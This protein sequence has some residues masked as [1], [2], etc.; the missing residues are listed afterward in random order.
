[1]TRVN[2][3]ILQT[4]RRRKGWSQDRLSEM[5]GV[6]KQTISRIER[7]KQDS[8]QENTIKLLARALG[9]EPAEL[10]REALAPET[11]RESEPV[12]NKSPFGLS[13]AADNALYLV[14]E[15]YWVKHWQIMELAPL[16]FCWAA[17][18]SLRERRKR[19]EKLKE[20][21][22]TA[23][24]LEQEMPHLPDPNFSYSEEKIKKETESIESH[25]LFATTMDTEDFIDGPFY[26]TDRNENPFSNFLEKQIGAL[27]TVATFEEFPAFDWPVY[28]VCPDEA[29]R[30]VD[31]DEELAEAV[32]DGR[33]ALREMPKKLQDSSIL[34]SAERA[35]WAREQLEE[36]HKRIMAQIE[37][38]T[39]KPKAVP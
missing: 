23:R 20:A 35:A 29:L 36:E 3:F 19:L 16:L 9:V 22:E 4:L 11:A 39:Q 1:M 30:F 12:R 37:R 21:C 34:M 13:I 10:T 38:K 27:G 28:Q 6:N 33:V 18:M 2:P 26:P 24:A 31:K 32:L 17:E 8:T 15:R 14:A 7:G 25:D 5:A